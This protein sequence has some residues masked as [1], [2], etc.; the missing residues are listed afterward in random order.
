MTASAPPGSMLSAWP[1]VRVCARSG[2]GGEAAVRS[3]GGG[4]PQRRAS[5][6]VAG[7][8]MLGPTA[9]A[10][11]LQELDVTVGSSHADP[12]AVADQ[13]GCLFDAHDGRQTVLPGDYRAVGHHA[14]HLGDQAR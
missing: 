8:A 7:L 13:S 5:D 11:G 6:A 12:L 3:A 2:D 4:Q 14:A 9:V 10:R 1:E